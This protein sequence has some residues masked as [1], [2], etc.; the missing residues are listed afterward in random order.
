MSRAS[1]SAVTL[2]ADDDDDDGD[3]DS[4]VAVALHK[5]YLHTARSLKNILCAHRSRN[6]LLVL[7]K[8]SA[9]WRFCERA[10]TCTCL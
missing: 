1:T 9:L 10:T 2:A 8:R 3:G 7:V 4:Q 6:H 5:V